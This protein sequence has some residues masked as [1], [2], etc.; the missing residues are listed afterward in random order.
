MTKFEKRL[1]II[2]TILVALQTLIMLIELLLR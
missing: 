2:T 1:L